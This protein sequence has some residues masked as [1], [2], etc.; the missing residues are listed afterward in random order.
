MGSILVL[1]AFALSDGAP[2][3]VAS[4][5]LILIA[6]NHL[7]SVNKDRE[8]NGNM[9]AAVA[10]YAIGSIIGFLLVYRASL[11]S[12]SLALLVHLSV[13]ILWPLFSPGLQG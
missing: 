1:F 11:L 9:Q 7:S 5:I 13:P 4:L 6:V 12:Q 10:L 3:F 2:L 8:L